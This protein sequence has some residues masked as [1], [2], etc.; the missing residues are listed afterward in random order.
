MATKRKRQTR[1]DILATS[2]LTEGQ[3]ADSRPALA[4][5]PTLVAANIARHRKKAKKKVK[6]RTP[7]KTARKTAPKKKKAK[8][9]ALKK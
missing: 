4:G 2:L 5:M 7:A 8:K 6:T 1:V 3:F 9:A